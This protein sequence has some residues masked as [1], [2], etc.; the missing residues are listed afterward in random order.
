MDM[1]NSFGTYGCS[2]NGCN[3][4]DRLRCATDF[5]GASELRNIIS[6]YTNGYTCPC[7]FVQNFSV[8][9]PNVLPTGVLPIL[10]SEPQAQ[11]SL[12]F[13]RLLASAKRLD[14]MGLDKC[15]EKTL[16]HFQVCYVPFRTFDIATGCGSITT[17]AASDD[18]TVTA[19]NYNITCPTVTNSSQAFFGSN[20]NYDAN[21]FVA[22]TTTQFTFTNPLM[23]GSPLVPIT[24]YGIGPSNPTTPLT[25]GTFNPN[26][27]PIYFYGG[28]F[29]NSFTVMADCD[30]SY[31]YVYDVPPCTV[32]PAP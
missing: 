7:E 18:T 14:V 3:Q 2:S 15:T 27:P 8:T 21:Q 17:V 9:S 31:E 13:M 32:Q 30:Y 10:Y 4:F 11:A 1:N 24:T 16:Y 5:A 26:N 25:S 28:V 20:P 29:A 19:N 22:L 6:V 12:M 23:G